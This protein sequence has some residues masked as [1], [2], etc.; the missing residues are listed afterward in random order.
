MNL[1]NYIQA[2]NAQIMTLWHASIS[3]THTKMVLL[4]E[5]GHDVLASFPTFM[6]GYNMFIL[7]FVSGCVCVC[8]CVR[9]CV[10]ACLCVCVC[11]CAFISVIVFSYK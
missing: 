7:L 3:D 8:V 9:A 6:Q 1:I 10:R 4:A 2:E 11:V 5:T